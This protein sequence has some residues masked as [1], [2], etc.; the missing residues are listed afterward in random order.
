M[1]LDK[2]IADMQSE[3]R[4]AVRE[5]IKRGAVTV[6]GEVVK[7]PEYKV[8]E[9]EDKIC[10]M[11]KE[12]C[13]QQFVYYML[14]KPADVV[15]ATKDA[16]ERTVMDLMREASGKN[17]FPVG[18]LDKDTEGLLL[19]TN[20]GALSHRL[21]S[22]KRHVEKTYYVECEGEL[23]TDAVFRLEQGV[24]IGDDK[25]TLPAGVNEIK[26]L[27]GTYSLKLSITEG[28]FHQVKRMI[29]AVG[30]NVTYLKRISFGG[31]KLDETLSTGEWRLLRQEEIE[32]LMEN[33]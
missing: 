20:D 7:K 5:Y 31:L 33:K 10:L 19:V 25:L 22:P 3:T 9:L 13:F 30:G 14:H 27:D 26:R 2:F 21:L 32:Q 4:S 24:D 29:Q 11:G 1:R 17:L 23:S 18:R 6:N 16:R 8:N 15:T 12:L 28:R